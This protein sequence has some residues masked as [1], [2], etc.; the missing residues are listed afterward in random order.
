MPATSR[1]YMEIFK[2]TRDISFNFISQC[3]VSLSLQGLCLLLIEV[4]RRQLI[5]SFQRSGSP[6]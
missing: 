2:L 6:L 1:V 5:Y 3:F 4:L